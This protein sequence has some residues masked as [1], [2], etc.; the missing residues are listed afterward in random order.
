MKIKTHGK[1]II[2]PAS[3]ETY[4]MKDM[5]KLVPGA[6]WDTVVGGW[7]FPA[8]SMTASAL[9]LMLPQAEVDEGFEALLAKREQE[10][11]AQDIKVSDPD[12]MEG[13]DSKTKPWGHQKK[14][15][16][17]VRQRWGCKDE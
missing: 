1:L 16:H 6:K 10:L 17:F 15:H 3:N 2:I 11:K 4:R 13:Y 5:L 9:R 7:T 8:A 12:N 14:A